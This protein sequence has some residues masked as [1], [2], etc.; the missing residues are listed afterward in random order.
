M[1]AN[2]GQQSGFVSPIESVAV[3]SEDIN[4][5]AELWAPALSL[6]QGGS[7][8]YVSAATKSNNNQRCI[9]AGVPVWG[10]NALQE[11]AWF[12]TA[13]VKCDPRGVIDAS[14]FYDP[15]SGKHYLYYKYDD[16][17]V[18]QPSRIAVSELAADRVS[19]VPG[20]EQILVQ[21]ND[22]SDWDG[23]V[24][25]APSMAY[26][27]NAT[28]PYVMLF[29]GSGYAGLSYATGIAYCLTP[30]TGCQYHW[31]SGGGNP[32]LSTARTGEAGPGGAEWVVPGIPGNP[33]AIAYHSGVPPS[34]RILRF[35][36][37]QVPCMSVSTQEPYCIGAA[38]RGAPQPGAAAAVS[39]GDVDPAFVATLPRPDWMPAPES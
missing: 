32:F 11:R 12:I 33:L 5:F 38:A 21:A 23:L 31:E 34:Q 8:I 1:T 26:L 22:P 37:V 3:L 10:K 14:P 35:R 24:V 16:N 7:F 2:N 39:V 17:S 13:K 29:S 20:T 27:P 28:L 4:W 36:S 6:G 25:E 15:W 18:G 9:W 19:L 30:T